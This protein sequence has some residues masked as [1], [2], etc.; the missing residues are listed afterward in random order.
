V[1]DAGRNVV[2]SCHEPEGRPLGENSQVSLRPV[3][4]C[5]AVEPLAKHLCVDRAGEYCVAAHT[6]GCKFE[7]SRPCQRDERTLRDGVHGDIHRGGDRM[8]GTDVHD[9]ATHRSKEWVGSPNALECRTDI[10]VDDQLPV[11]VFGLDDWLVDLDGCVID[12]CMES[13]E[14]GIEPSEQIRD[15]I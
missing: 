2:G 11:G 1:K 9:G 5:T 8:N 7:C 3:R 10:R 13:V 15:L 4:I 12:Q 6:V 14:V